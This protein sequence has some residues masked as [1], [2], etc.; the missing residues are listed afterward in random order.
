MAAEVTHV[1]FNPSAS[2]SPLTHI[3][4]EWERGGWRLVQVVPHHQYESVAVFERLREPQEEAY[5]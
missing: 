4:A 1:V 5:D 3:C 2:H